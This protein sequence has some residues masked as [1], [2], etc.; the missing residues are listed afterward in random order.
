MAN[1]IGSPSSGAST[2]VHAWHTRCLHTC[3]SQQDWSCFGTVTSPWSHSSTELVQFTP[4]VPTVENVHSSQELFSM[5]HRAI[6][7]IA[8]VLGIAGLAVHPRCTPKRLPPLPRR[9]TRVPLPGTHP[10]LGGDD[11]GNSLRSGAADRASHGGCGVRTA[12][13]ITTRSG[14]PRCRDRQADVRRTGRRLPGS[15]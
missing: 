4:P 5:Q 14:V 15:N 6:A 3:G 8:L 2:L 13:G 10:E 12:A 7:L 1:P 9:A 11:A